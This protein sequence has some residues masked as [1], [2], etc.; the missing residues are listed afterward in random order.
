MRINVKREKLRDE[1][2]S[3][4]CSLH[5][6]DEKNLSFQFMKLYWRPTWYMHMPFNLNLTLQRFQT[7]MKINNKGPFNVIIDYNK[8][9]P[10]FYV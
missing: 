6:N 2:T 3:N 5:C 1:N 9:R 10:I 7:D 4:I 8:V